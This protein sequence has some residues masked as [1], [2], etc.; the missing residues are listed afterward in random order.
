MNR[1]V[2]NGVTVMFDCLTIAVM[3]GCLKIFKKWIWIEIIMTALSVVAYII[4]MLKM[5]ES[6]FWLLANSKTDKVVK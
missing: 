1:E 6:I 4:T 5:P 2:E 3:C